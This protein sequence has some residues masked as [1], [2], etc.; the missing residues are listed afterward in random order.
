M[1]K[2]VIL[3]CADCGT[4]NYTTNSNKGNER[5]ELKKFCSKCSAHT[6]HRETK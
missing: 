4:R 5:L 1:P 6:V 3:A 2:K